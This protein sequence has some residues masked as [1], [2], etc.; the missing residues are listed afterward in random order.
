MVTLFRWSQRREI[1]CSE[2]END[3]R[4]RTTSPHDRRGRKNSV[5]ERGKRPKGVCFA[6]NSRPTFDSCRTTHANLLPRHWYDIVGPIQTTLHFQDDCRTRAVTSMAQEGFSF[7]IYL[8]PT[9]PD[10]GGRGP[11]TRQ[12][13]AAH[14]PTM[15]FADRLE[16]PLIYLLK[17]YA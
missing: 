9:S 13:R 16:N 6:P 7:S 12:T 8:P 5:Q 15:T 1:V 17:Y 4:L 14:S 11:R 3:N 2:K 10:G